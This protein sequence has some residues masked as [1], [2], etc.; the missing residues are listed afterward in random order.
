VGV[1]LGASAAAIVCTCA[2]AAVLSL[3]SPMR[4]F[5]RP[6]LLVTLYGALALLVSI[7]FHQW[8]IRRW[9]V[10]TRPLMN[11]PV[12]IPPSRTVQTANLSLCDTNLSYSRALFASSQG[13]SGVRLQGVRV[14]AYRFAGAQTHNTSP[15]YR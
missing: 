3:T 5:C 6:W 7:R 4:W 14:G 2:L 12:K 15:S 1:F 10:T 13:P 9:K 11:C 8:S